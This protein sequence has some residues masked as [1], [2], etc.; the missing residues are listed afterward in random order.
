VIRCDS[1][2]D[3][4]IK[5][6]HSAIFRLAQSYGI[7]Q[8]CFKNRLKIRERAADHL[9]YL[10]CGGLLLQCFG[11]L[12][13]AILQVFEQPN[14]L[15]GDHGLV[16]ESF[17]ERDLFLGKR[18]ELSPANMNS[19]DWNILPEQW[20]RQDSANLTGLPAFGKFGLGLRSR[21]VMDVNCLSVDHGSADKSTPGHRSSFLS[22]EDRY[23]SMQSDKPKLIA[24]STP[25][26]R[27]ACLTQPRC[28]FCHHIQHR[29]NIG[30]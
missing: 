9:Q 27:V 29:L 23:R 25:N 17:E 10:T 4:S 5:S 13:V 11:E 12:A 20:S 15:D 21:Y 8:D 3:L 26:C 19:P 30:R 24:V 16:S 1:P 7:I 14:I 6:E 22:S 18:S 2:K 28:I